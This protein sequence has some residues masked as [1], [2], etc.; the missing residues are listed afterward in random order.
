MII[1]HSHPM[2]R[3]KWKAAGKD[4]YNG[5]Y[6]YSREIVENII[7]RVETDRSW[8]TVNVRDLACSHSIVFVHNNLHPENYEWLKQYDDL[9]LV[10]GVPQ[11]CEKVAH[12]GRAVYLPL[13]VDIA[14]VER[15]KRQKD[16]ETAF[17]GRPSKAKGIPDG[18]DMLSGMPREDLLAEMARYEKVYAVGRTA[19]EARVLGCKVLMY[20]ERFPNPACWE[21][22]DNAEA[23]KML[24][25]MLDE[26]G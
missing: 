5:A 18:V 19:I 26:I 13:S 21:P 6:Y 1:D 22:L 3:A 15:F 2:Y 20:D 16:R 8:I 25:A 9:V 12:L 11:T 7:P 10:C 24:Q 14:E 23:A 4:R 17:A